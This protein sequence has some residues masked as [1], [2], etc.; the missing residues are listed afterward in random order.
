MEEA[1][2]RHAL[3]ALDVIYAHAGTVS[4]L[5]TRL[6][7]SSPSPSALTGPMEATPGAVDADGQDGAAMR[8]YSQRGWVRERH[9][10]A[11]DLAP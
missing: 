10:L 1:L 8:P 4:L 3:S 9:T 11:E 2:F 6:P 5:S 7:S